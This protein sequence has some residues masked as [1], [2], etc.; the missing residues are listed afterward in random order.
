[1][2]TSEIAHLVG[3][4]M[5]GDGGAEITS[6]AGISAASC[7]QAAFFEGSD[8][9]AAINAS[10]VLVPTGAKQIAGVTTIE[11][12]NPKL[13]FARLA[14]V[15][16]PPKER[17]PQIHPSAVISSSASVGADVF[18]GAF[19]CIGDG[20]RIGGGSQLRA[21]CNVG[22]NVSTGN[23]CVLHTNVSLEDNTTL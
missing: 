23:N 20:S 3:G 19:V 2:K 9:S 8:F 18:I 13:A 6:V 7:G 21:G 11:V 12:E 5:H 22:D 17:A 4:K 10:C 16:H 1:M 14:A 15:L